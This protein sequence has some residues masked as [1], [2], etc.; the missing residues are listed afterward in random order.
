MFCKFYINPELIKAQGWVN[1]TVWIRLLS[2]LIVFV[3]WVARVSWNSFTKLSPTMISA[4]NLKTLTISQVTKQFFKYQIVQPVPTVD[5]KY[6][7]KSNTLTSE[8][9]M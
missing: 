4:T 2:K 1:I 5:I 6:V 7:D 8:G 9:R 3:C